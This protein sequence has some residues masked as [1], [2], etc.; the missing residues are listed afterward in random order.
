MQVSLKLFIA[1][2]L[3]IIGGC[4]QA[5]QPVKVEIKNVDGNFQLYRGGKP[6]H[7]KGAGIEVSDFEAFVKH[8]GN[9]IRNWTTTNEK[10]STLSILDKAHEL[11]LTVSLCLPMSKEHWGFNYSDPVAVKKQLDFMR[12]EVLKYKDHPALLTWIIGNELNF[13]YTNSDVYNAVNDVAKMIKEIDPY[14]PTTTTVAGLEKRV[15]KD[16]QERAPALDFVSMQVYGQLALLPEFIEQTDYDGPYMVTE[17]G[18]VGFWE[19]PKTSWGA[20]I[21]MTSTQ[22]AQNT[23]RGYNE[24]IAT[25]SSRVIGNHVFLWGQK[26]ERTPTWFGMFTDS[27]METESVDVMHFIWNNKW[28][29]NRSPRLNQMLLDNKNAHQNVK[30]EASNDYVAIVDSSDPDGD[31][32]SYRWEIKPESDSKKVGGDFEKDIANIDSTVNRL[33]KSE[34]SFT[35]PKRP[36][37]YRLFVYVYDGQGHAAHANIP[38]YVE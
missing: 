17:W 3:L 31:T 24:K 25:Q 22:K 23:L 29:K 10:E 26:Q 9:S 33:N 5:F 2:A 21:E 38:F 37:A 18:T 36:G 34:I 32:L 7:I 12:G 35:T 14:H 28:P 20:P 13:D 6:Y 30:L 4:I 15:L 27:G 1:S 11:G 19:M 16:I 8:G